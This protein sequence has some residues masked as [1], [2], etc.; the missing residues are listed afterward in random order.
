VN[1][2]MAESMAI[3][4]THVVTAGAV[5]DDLTTLIRAAQADRKAFGTLYDRYVERVYAYLRARVSDPE[6]ARDLTQHVFLRAL[7]ALPR[8]RGDGAAFAAWLF[9]IARN[10]STNNHSRRRPTIPL[11]MVSERRQP[12]AASGP[13]LAAMQNEAAGELRVLLADLPKA[14]QELLA[15]RFAGGLSAG[16]IAM[17]IGKSEAATRKQLTRTLQLL[18]ERYV[19]KTGVQHRD[20]S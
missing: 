9:R 16:Q 13:E 17:V 3:R 20:R 6:E 4:G 8:Y 7:D 10:A 11:E 15:L 12:L 1:G 14:K 5:D 19:Q 18:H 2:V